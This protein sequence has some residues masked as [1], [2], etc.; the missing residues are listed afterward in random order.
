MRRLVTPAQRLV[1]SNVCPSI[2]NKII[3]DKLQTMGVKLV[4]GL[5]HLRVGM[6][7]SEYSHVL[8][9]RRQVF[10]APPE[11]LIADSVTITYEETV[12]RIFLT[13]D[14]PSCT[15]CKQTGH[16]IAQCTNNHSTPQQNT[17]PTKI[18]ADVSKLST[19]EISNATGTNQNFKRNTSSQKK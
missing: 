5:T 12:Y 9:F 3:E 2:P 16:T 10:I 4:S 19:D 8:S 17:T 1:V 13:I 18:T 11:S 7:E 6:P 15:R 14:G